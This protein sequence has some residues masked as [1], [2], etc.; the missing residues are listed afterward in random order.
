MQKLVMLD[1]CFMFDPADTFAHSYQFEKD[2]TTFFAEHD[3]E[4][5]IVAPMNGYQGRKV[6]FISKK[7]AIAPLEV[8]P[9]PGAVQ[10]QVNKLRGMK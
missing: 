10:K 7:P 5:Q 4:A 2:L 8:A 9:K 3:M 6:L 1:Y